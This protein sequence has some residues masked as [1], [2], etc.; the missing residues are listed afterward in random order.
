M[1]NNYSIIYFV[2]L[3]L[4]IYIKYS[5]RKFR[6][7]TLKE[8]FKITLNKKIPKVIHC[9]YY[10]KHEIPDKIWNNLKLY[11]PD[12][13]I[14]FYNDDAC[15][16]F[17]EKNFN[18]QYAEKFKH[19]E[20]GCH[21]ADFFR[22]CVM[23]CEGGIY[24]DIKIEP[25]IHFKNIFDHETENIFYTCLGQQG[26][27]E[28]PITKYIRRFR[29][30]NNGHIFQALLATYPG[31]IFFKKLIK[32]FFIVDNPQNNYHIFTYRFYDH[33]YDLLGYHLYAGKHKYGDQELILFK[34]INQKMSEEDLLDRHGGYYY[35]SDEYNNILFRSR[36]TDFP[37]NEK[38]VID[39][40]MTKVILK[41]INLKKIYSFIK[42]NNQN[43][44]FKYLNE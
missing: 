5:E 26:R 42:I 9:T 23:Y 4:F 7:V 13:K 30:E 6:E 27:E 22:Y 41:I 29:G 28:S 2:I 40:P 43:F 19:L 10:N 31:N 24:L 20:L 34:E 33:L 32:D 14:I 15:Y 17:I 44:N 37:W 16:N 12:Y 35:I 1:S 39:N 21:K 3:I 8:N 11:A 25:K 36:Y 38:F 18:Q